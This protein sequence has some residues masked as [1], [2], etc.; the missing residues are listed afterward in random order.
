M[1]YESKLFFWLDKF[2][3]SKIKTHDMAKFSSFEDFRDSHI[4]DLLKNCYV[5]DLLQILK[6]ID[7]N[8]FCENG[9]DIF[10]E[11]QELIGRRNVHIH[12]NGITDRAYI[13]GFN[14]YKKVEGEILLIDIDVLQRTQQLSNFIV[15][16]MVKKF[17]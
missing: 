8:I 17:G 2:E 9:I 11:M 10:P 14:I 12:N 4:C 16:E 5:K 7:D 15:Q 13:E 1:L 6:N 3:N